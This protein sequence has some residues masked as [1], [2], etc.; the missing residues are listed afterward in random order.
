[1]KRSLK[2]SKPFNLNFLKKNNKLIPLLIIIVVTFIGGFCV[3]LMLGNKLNSSIEGLENANDNMIKPG[4]T[5]YFMEN[6]GHC[7]KFTP[8]WDDFTKKYKTE[9]LPKITMNK[10]E[11]KEPKPSTHE[12]AVQG[13]PTVLLDKNN[14]EDPI[15]FK[16][17]RT[18]K[19]LEDFLKEH[20]IL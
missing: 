3:N 19:G 11:S 13:Y 15:E 20:N 18:V 14:G 9:L 8:E 10:V 4:L 1:M 17:D 12:D 7:K 16:K 5:Y 6:C 2:Y